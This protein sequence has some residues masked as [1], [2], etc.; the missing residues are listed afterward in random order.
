VTPGRG[1]KERE[2]FLKRDERRADKRNEREE[3]R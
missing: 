2:Y 1:E 3:R